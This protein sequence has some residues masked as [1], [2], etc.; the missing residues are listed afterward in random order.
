M[1]R[2][3]LLLRTDEPCGAVVLNGQTAQFEGFAADTFR[4]LRAEQGD[5]PLARD[6]LA[7]GWSN[8][9]TLYLGPVQP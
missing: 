5:L 1:R 4:S 2:D 3:L 8:G 6:L 9:F 7:N